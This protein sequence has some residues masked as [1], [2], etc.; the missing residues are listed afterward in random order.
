MSG[1]NFRGGYNRQP[2]YGGILLMGP[3]NPASRGAID[4]LGHGFAG[5]NCSVILGDENQN[6]TRINDVSRNLNPLNTDHIGVFGK[7]DVIS[8]SNFWNDEPKDR[9]DMIS[10]VQN[11]RIQPGAFIQNRG[12]K[13]GGELQ[14]DVIQIQKVPEGF[15]RGLGYFGLLY[16]S[17]GL[18]NAERFTGIKRSRAQDR[19]PRNER[20]KRKTG[21]QSKECQK[22]S[23]GSQGHRVLAKLVKN[24]LIRRADCATFGQ[25]K[26]RS[27]RDDHR[28]DLADQS[29]ADR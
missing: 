26:S 10:H 29:I 2:V 4:R 25:Q 18:R 9:G 5:R 6:L 17:G 1:H 22:G 13:V 20:E 24:R 7:P 3:I 27:N 8:H 11:A 15:F 16:Q 21:D 23:D 28:W 19:G 12:H 14:V